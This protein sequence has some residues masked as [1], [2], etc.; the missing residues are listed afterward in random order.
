MR[1]TLMKQSKLDLYRGRSWCC[2]IMRVFTTSNGLL[3]HVETKP[4]SHRKGTGTAVDRCERAV[5]HTAHRS[6][7]RCVKVAHTPHLAAVVEGKST[8][9][10]KSSS[11]KG[12]RN[13][14]EEGRNPFFTD[15]REKC[16]RRILVSWL[17][18]HHDK[19]PIGLHADFDEV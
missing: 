16:I 13:T 18:A 15:D 4:I 9:C 2:S 6:R 10:K 1:T 14:G 5:Y 11:N 7:I 12:G 19:T 17:F 8:H 3:M